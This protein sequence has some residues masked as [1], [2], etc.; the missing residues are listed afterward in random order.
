VRLVN[1]TIPGFKSV[2][3]GIFL[4]V[5]SSA[6]SEKLAG[7]SH[8][9]EHLIFKGSDRY[10]SD[11]IANKIDST[12]GSFNAYTS[13]EHTTFYFKVLSDDVSEML[14]IFLDVVFNPK[15][16]KSDID[17]ER[18]VV[19]SE[20]ASML[21][22]PD[23]LSHNGIFD[24]CW[25]SHPAARPVLGSSEVIKSIDT[26]SLRK[27]HSSEYLQDNAVISFCGG[28]S[29]DEIVSMLNDKG[30]NV[31][32]ST[33]SPLVKKIVPPRH[34]T[35]T[36]SKEFDVEQIYFNYVWQGPDLISDD[37]E[38]ALVAGSVLSGSY[39]SRLFRR[40]REKEGLVYGISGLSHLFTFAGL[41]GVAGSVPRDKFKRMEEVLLE[42]I[43]GFKREGV[44]REELERSKSMIRGSVAISLEGNMA[45]MHRNGKLAL[46]LGRIKSL[47]ELLERID[48]IEYEEINDYI[49]GLIPEKSSVSVVGKDIEKTTGIPVGLSMVA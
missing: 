42:E 28:M 26:E 29:E 21:D 33:P 8:F 22:D 34:N 49:A 13:V 24:A 31:S 14:D 16:A 2:A 25:G 4:P 23:D 46:L 48:A 41:M 15:L 20:I 6:E 43:A 47:D 3:C 12:G 19:L 1:H 9:M 37:I 36:Y 17:K 5:G 39:S 27:F 40:L 32:S 11:I 7:V 45:S 30:I 44:S 10:D 38:K 35:G 18:G